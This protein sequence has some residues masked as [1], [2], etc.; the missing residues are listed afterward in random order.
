MAL[1]YV[2][3]VNLNPGDG[4]SA[5]NVFRANQMYDPNYTG[6]GHQPMFFDNYAALYSKY[7]VNSAT[8]TMVPLQNHIVNTTVNNQTAGTTV[9]TDQYF[10]SNEHA[11][12]MFILVDESPSDYPNDLDNL[13]EEGNK[14]LRWRYVPQTTSASMQKLT[15]KILPHKA[16]NLSFNDHALACG[17]TSD[18]LRPL[19]FICGV[20]SF[21]TFNAD[22][23]KY[24]IFITYNVTFF[25]F[26]GAQSQN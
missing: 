24:Q 23:M 14:R 13:I 18:P 12:R 4:T 7:K 25:D 22:G 11:V 17:T 19:Y 1:R 15:M 20:D 9:S 2:E 16:M 6:A 5:V 21:D 3:T 8:V 26:I 10:Q